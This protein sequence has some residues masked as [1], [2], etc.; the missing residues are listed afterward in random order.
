MNY[1][2]SP[3]PDPVQS[4]NPIV[5]NSNLHPEGAANCQQTTNYIHHHG[6]EINRNIRRV[7]PDDQR[8]RLP[9]QLDRRPVARILRHRNGR[10]QRTV[11]HDHVV[12]VPERH[13]VH[14]VLRA[15]GGRQRQQVQVSLRLFVRAGD[16]G[17]A[18]LLPRYYLPA[19]EGRHL[20]HIRREVR[21]R[22]RIVRS[23]LGVLVGRHG[24]AAG[25]P[26]H[27]VDDAFHD[28]NGR[29]DNG[30]V[31]E[32]AD[33][34]GRRKIGHRVYDHTHHPEQ[35]SG[36][37]PIRRGVPVARFDVQVLGRPS[38]ENERLVFIEGTFVCKSEGYIECCN[39]FRFGPSNDD[40]FHL[41]VQ[42][43]VVSAFVSLGYL[44]RLF[45]SPLISLL[46]GSYTVAIP[47][48]GSTAFGWSTVQIANVLAAQAIVLFVSMNGSMALS[49]MT[50][51]PDS[52]MIIGGNMFFVVG[53]V[54]T[55]FSWKV[56]AAT[57]QFVLP[58]MLI[59]LA[60]PSMGPANR[61]SFT[62]AMHSHPGKCCARFIQ[63]LI[64]FECLPTHLEHALYRIGK[65]HWNY[66]IDF[67]SDDHDRRFYYAQPCGKVCLA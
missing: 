26:A 27:R 49:M 25:K 11:R 50:E 2:R 47:P 6:M 65:L 52:V 54:M 17:I 32:C 53:G 40:T 67:L 55:Y 43:Y 21:H 15:V 10:D 18:R 41:D 30:S 51:I 36:I 64:I 34:E 13:N 9:H 5:Q 58:I 8:H 44:M 22:H 23:D 62:M 56:G 14:V 45:C 57:W 46:R 29:H 16:G 48:V 19:G 63:Y 24:G 60:Y 38:R 33:R 35:L 7:A 3:Q 1:H 28:P 31:A 61:S 20:R 12:L 37:D 66:A 4:S 59:T 42:L 39:K